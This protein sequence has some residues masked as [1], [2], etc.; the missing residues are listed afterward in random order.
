[1]FSGGNFISPS[2]L[3]CM[4]K[5]FFF[6][7]LLKSFSI[8]SLEEI[9]FSFY[10]LCMSFCH[11]VKDIKKLKIL[12]IS[13]RYYLSYKILIQNIFM[14]LYCFS[15]YRILSLCE[16]IESRGNRIEWKKKKEG[17][18]PFSGKKGI[19]YKYLHMSIT[20]GNIK[21]TGET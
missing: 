6:N 2:L 5:K 10:M 3:L 16:R 11:V 8:Q 18:E 12:K 20:L 17:V 4:I 19:N 1:M 15:W 14:I 9:F 21:A 13:K 7:I